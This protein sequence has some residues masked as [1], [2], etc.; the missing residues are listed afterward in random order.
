MRMYDIIEK[1]RNGG[2]LTGSEIAWFVQNYTAE[3]LPDYQ[4]AALLMAIFLNGMQPQETAALT[5]Q[6]AKSGEELELSRFGNLTADKHSTGGVG[7]KTTL[8]VAP[9][10]AAAGVK[11]AKLS[12]RGLGFTGGTV[13]KLEAIPGYRTNLTPQEFLTQVEQIG[14]A[15]TGQSGNLAPADK[16][17]YALRDVTA[18]VESLPLIT[19]SIMSKKLAAGSKNIVLDVK[20]GSGAFMKTKEQAL[21]LAESM[22]HIGQRCG[23]SMTALITNMNIPLGNEIGNANEVSEAAAVLQGRVKG[24]LRELC[25]ALAANMVCLAFGKPFE[26]A[27]QQV[28]QLLENGAAFQ[29]MQQWVSAQGGDSGYLTNPE[30]FPQP[31][32]LQPVLA[33]AGGYITAMDSAKVGECCVVLGAGRSVKNEKIDPLAGITLLRHLGDLVQKGEPVALLR[34]NR[35]AALQTGQQLLSAAIKIGSTPPDS[36]PLIYK[37]VR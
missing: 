9:L 34:T 11:V 18:T 23:R 30:L 7:D 15:V 25:L 13:D 5:L 21:A 29:K 33:P 22:V 3:Q 4:A 19:S 16:K 8:I 1:K 12:G 31:A 14:I 20:F 37:T 10:A 17:L 32:H 6:M 35:A 36:E 26:A 24:P 2:E 28:T 27:L